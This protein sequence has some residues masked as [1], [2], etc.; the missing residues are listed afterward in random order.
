MS[1][2]FAG[3]CPASEGEAQSQD[4]AFSQDSGA[5]LV[6]LSFHPLLP[7]HLAEAFGIPKLFIPGLV[8][9]P[10]AHA[11]GGSAWQP[12]PRTACAAAGPNAAGQP[13]T[14]GPSAA[15][16]SGAGPGPPANAACA[17]TALLLAGSQRQPLPTTCAAAARPA[18]APVPPCTYPS[19]RPPTLSKSPQ[20]M[21]QTSRAGS[22]G[23]PTRLAGT[24]CRTTA[25]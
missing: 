19:T 2:L 6:P 1:V 25:T 7:P 10:G 8:V 4:G 17:L 16:A 5:F 15:A 22:M 23:P 14:W 9:R 18:P 24:R 21:R 13:A 3:R 20:A 12:V 11:R